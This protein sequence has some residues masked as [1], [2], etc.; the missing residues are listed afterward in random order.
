M[1][2]QELAHRFF[3]QPELRGEYPRV[4]TSFSHSHYGWNYYSYSTRIGTIKQN[5]NGDN[6]LLISEE[7]YSSTT[8]KHLAELVHACPFEHIYV[9]NCETDRFGF[10]RALT[11]IVDTDLCEFNHKKSREICKGILWSYDEYVK[12]FGH[13][14]KATKKLRAS[15]EIKTAT[16]AIRIVEEKRR[17]GKPEKSL[18]ELM[19]AKNRRL[20]EKQLKITREIR[21][22][23]KTDDKLKML[24]LAYDYDKTCCATEQGRNMISRYRATLQEATDT[25]GRRLS[26]IWVGEDNCCQTSQHCYATVQEVKI[27][28]ERWSLDRP[29]VG[30][31][32]GGWTCLEVTSELIKVGCHIFPMWNVLELC[33]KLGVKTDK[34]AS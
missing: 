13:L 17:G 23:L 27:A 25:K 14:N 34:K 22:T 2:T 3:H 5:M 12:N 11:E 4:K 15:K 24:K 20:H 6:V 32:I 18:E 19:T 16:E 26:Y 10:E 7:G 8:R 9:P 28:L 30:M 1:T 31:K 29:I 21:E 33:K